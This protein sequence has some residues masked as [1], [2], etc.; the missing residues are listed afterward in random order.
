MNH[1]PRISLL[2]ATALLGVSFAAALSVAGCAAAERQQWANTFTAA[3]DD[4]FLVDDDFVCLGDERFTDV[5]GRRIWNVFDRTRQEQAVALAKSGLPGTYP[6]GTVIQLFPGEAMVKRGRGFAP[7]TND[8]EYFVLDTSSGTSVITARGSTDVGNLAGSC[9]SCHGAAQA[10]DTVCFTNSSCRDLP[11]FVDTNVD[12]L[13][14][15]ERC[16]RPAP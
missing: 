1:R 10:F 7:A 16:A 11:F 6:V 9:I 5:A 13:T 3:G 14:E 12:P 4:A 15:D 8:W 2:V